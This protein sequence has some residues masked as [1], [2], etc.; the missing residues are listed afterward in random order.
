MS[1]TEELTRYPPPR[2][3]QK[4]KKAHKCDCIPRAR[5]GLLLYYALPYPLDG[6]QLTQGNVRDMDER[7]RT[8]TNTSHVPTLH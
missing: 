8:D 4:G 3:G 5:L 6:R 2:D 1:T 7:H